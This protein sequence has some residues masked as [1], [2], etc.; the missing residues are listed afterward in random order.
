MRPTI[1]SKIDLRELI[2]DST[3]NWPLLGI[4]DVL[5]TRILTRI[6]INNETTQLVTI[7]LVTGKMPKLVISSEIKLTPSAEAKTGIVEKKE[8]LE[9]EISN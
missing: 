1:G 2:A 4:K 8:R 5:P 9:E 6:T 7:E 3:I